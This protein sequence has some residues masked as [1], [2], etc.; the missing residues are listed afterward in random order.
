MALVGL[1]AGI[2]CVVLLPL[3]RL[4][5]LWALPWGAAWLNVLALRRIAYR[6]PTL[7][8]RKAA[9][10]GLSLAV[11]FGIATP[12][13]WMTHQSL[14]RRDARAFCERWFGYLQEDNPY[15][16]HLLSTEPEMRRPMDDTLVEAY[17]SA[18][19]QT[20]ELREFVNAKLIRTLLALGDVAEIRFYEIERQESLPGEDDVALVFAITTEVDQVRTTF[21][22]T[23]VVQ[24]LVYKENGRV[25]WR[26][27][28]TRGGVKPR[29]WE[30]S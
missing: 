13:S 14:V 22:A 28:A 21:F 8:G 3:S 17:M 4:Y 9:L 6:A 29:S 7:V 26:V 15:A 19:A 23:V 2:A 30:R 10:T 24:R 11:L 16:A 18:P 5:W 1:A 27:V 12:V 25:Y 20:E